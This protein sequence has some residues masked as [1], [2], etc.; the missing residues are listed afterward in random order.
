MPVDDA[1][2]EI[3]PL[4]VFLLGVAGRDAGAGEPARQSRFRALAQFGRLVEHAALAGREARQD[5][6]MD[7]RA[8][9]TTLGDLDGG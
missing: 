4:A 6:L 5:R 1:K 8:E 9:R 3:E 2:L 7:V